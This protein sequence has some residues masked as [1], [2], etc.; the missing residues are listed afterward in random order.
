MIKIILKNGEEIIVPTG[1]AAYL[2]QVTRTDTVSIPVGT[3]L[4]VKDKMSYGGE[5]V[6]SFV[7]SEVRGW[8]VEIDEEEA[9]NA[10]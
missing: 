9:T 4:E 3:M 7:A 5:I 8:A 6:A 2:V 10:D 1:R